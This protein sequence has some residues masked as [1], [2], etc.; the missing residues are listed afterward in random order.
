MKKLLTMALIAAAAFAAEG[1]KV[2][3][4]IKIG[5]RSAQVRTSASGSQWRAPEKYDHFE[6]KTL[7]R[8]Q[9]GDLVPDKAL[10]V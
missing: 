8:D 2:I 5:G 9:N 7:Q 6:L 10:M 1:Y 3:G 4:K